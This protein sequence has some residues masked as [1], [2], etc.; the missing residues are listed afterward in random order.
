MPVTQFHRNRD[1][2]VTRPTLWLSQFVHACSRL[3]V[4]ASCDPPEEPLDEEEEDAAAA[5]G[6]R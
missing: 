4:T 5:T 2:P 1:Y 6:Q 3:M